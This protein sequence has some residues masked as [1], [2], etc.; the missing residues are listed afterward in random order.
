M[1][2]I[3][4][5]L[6]SEVKPGIKAS[7]LDSMALKLAKERSAEPSFKNFQG[8]PANICISINNEVVHG[9][10]GNKVLKAGDILGLDFGIRYK[11]L[12]TDMAATVGVGKISREAQ[13][14]IDVTEKSLY[15]GIDQIR[16]GN[17]I[18]DMSYAIQTFVEKKGYAVVRELTGHGVGRE[19]HEPPQIPNFGKRGE[20]PL[21]KE[22][23]VL[24][25]EPM[26]NIGGPQ[27]ELKDDG[28]TFV[29][30]D[31]S[32]S[33]HFEHTVAVTRSSHEILT[34]M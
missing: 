22:G 7:V 24:A 19:V 9:L 4:E 18:G 17:R 34:K 28:W 13:D 30:E 21:L 16:P 11:G 29:T 3:L 15:I 5:I 12:Y 26:V 6:K 25:I 27:V 20:G 10:P 1:A 2:E 14:L 32:L 23:M 33:A 8:Y 31:G